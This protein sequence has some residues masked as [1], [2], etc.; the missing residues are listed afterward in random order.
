MFQRV[1]KL[2]QASYCCFSYAENWELLKSNVGT[3]FLEEAMFVYI[4]KRELGHDSLFYDNLFTKTDKIKYN[5]L[6]KSTETQHKNAKEHNKK[7]TKI[8]SD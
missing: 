7:T 4:L 6:S 8:N 1:Q 5:R 3:K 2:S